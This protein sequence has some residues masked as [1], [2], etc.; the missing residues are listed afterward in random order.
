MRRVESRLKSFSFLF[1]LQSITLGNALAAYSKY[2]GQLELLT[3]AVELMA[4]KHV[5]FYI[6]PEHYDIV[7][8]CLLKAIREVLGKEVAND[9]VMDA[10]AEGYK[11]LAEL[12]IDKEKEIRESRAAQKGL[13]HRTHMSVPRGIC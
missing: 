4:E 8:T 9:E 1:F 13:L 10:F 2:A 12:L 3:E 11:F 7:G 6:L 5:S